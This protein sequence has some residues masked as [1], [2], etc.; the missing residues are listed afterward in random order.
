MKKKTLKRLRVILYN[1]NVRKA[2]AV[3]EGKEIYFYYPPK[4]G[5]SKPPTIDGV[6][7]EYVSEHDSEIMEMNNGILVM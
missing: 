3:H 5:W 1:L 4:G 2:Y 6:E 7:L